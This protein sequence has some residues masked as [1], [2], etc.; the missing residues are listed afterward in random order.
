[1]SY[2]SD[3][4][5]KS[6]ILFQLGWDTRVRQMEINVTVANGIVTL[7]GTVDSYAKKIAAR[8][9]AHR[10]HGVLDVANDIEVKIPGSNRRTD[11]EI[12]QAVRHALEWNVLV[13]SDRIRSTVEKG[14]VTLEGDVEY[15]S[16][17]LD[18]E[19]AIHGL[20]GV[21]G[22]TN[23]IAVSATTD[24]EKVR[25]VIENVLELR[26]DREACR[27]RVT[28]RGGEVTLTGSINS[29]DERRAIL[30]A[31]GHSPGVTAIRDHLFIDPYGLEFK[32]ATSD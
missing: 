26:A 15:Y 13:P 6:E 20:A 22:V 10:V 7:T 21:H 23:K 17:R 11:S 27:I 16:E 5:I 1:M 14:W 24:Q 12:V 29:W 19:R 18:A 4:E 25:S 2:K 8:E 30:G 31:V 32:S 3:E 9:A 28:V